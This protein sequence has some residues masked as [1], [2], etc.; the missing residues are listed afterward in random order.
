MPMRP[1]SAMPMPPSGLPGGRPGPYPPGFGPLPTLPAPV[2]Y[3]QKKGRGGLIASII[4]AVIA[5]VAAGV[6]VYV[7]VLRPDGGLN[8]PERLAATSVAIDVRDDRVTISW[9]DPS[10]GEAQPIIVGNREG[11]GLRRFG[12]PARGATTHP[13][14]GLNKN[15]DYCFRVLLD[16]V[17]SVKESDQVCTNRKK[18]TPTPSR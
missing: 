4:A 6:T 10:N 16:Y 11:E 12:L 2:A 18:A 7:A 1:T 15:F 14:T 13:L 8:Q 5:I 9:A 17:D 3:P